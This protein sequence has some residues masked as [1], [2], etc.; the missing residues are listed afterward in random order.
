MYYLDANICIYFLKGKYQSLQEKLRSVSPNDI[1]IPAIVE[2]EIL[3]SVEKGAKKIT[4]KLWN[5]FFDAFE[6]IV[7][8]E[9][10]ARQYASIRA[11]LE[12]EGNTI[13]QNDLIIAAT[14]LAND[15]ILITAKIK[16]FKRVPNLII[17]DWTVENN[18][19]QQQENK[20]S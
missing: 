4:R 14:V 15:G 10:A 6:I 1:R 8:D 17:E 2:A 3:V 13:D 5:N 16:E 11:Y 12:K 19:P 9:A 18:S 7:F 20:P